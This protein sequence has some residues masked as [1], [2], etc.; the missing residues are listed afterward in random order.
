M[1]KEKAQQFIDDLQN[2]FDKYDLWIDPYIDY[3][4]KVVIDIIDKNDNVVFDN[5]DFDHDDFTINGFH[6]LQDGMREFICSYKG[7]KND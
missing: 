5:L 3:E 4:D 7:M 1:N 2:V 6:I